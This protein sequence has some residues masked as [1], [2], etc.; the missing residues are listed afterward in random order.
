MHQ[1]AYSIAKNEDMQ[2]V[3]KQKT[4][5]K[6]FIFTRIGLQEW[7]VTVRVKSRVEKMSKMAKK[8]Q[9]VI[10]SQTLIVKAKKSTRTMMTKTTHLQI[11]KKHQTNMK[12]I[13]IMSGLMKFSLTC[14]I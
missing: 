4:E 12:V 13:L 7:I 5:T 1:K 10:H 11:V 14:P 8:T 2:K 6:L 9:I 3:K